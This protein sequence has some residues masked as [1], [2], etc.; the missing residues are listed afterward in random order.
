MASVDSSLKKKDR[1]DGFLS[2]MSLA[3]LCI[4]MFYS[5]QI[6]IL[7]GRSYVVYLVIFLFC[8]IRMCF[9]RHTMSHRNFIACFL[10]LLM[11]SVLDLFHITDFPSL[12]VYVVRHVCLVWLVILLSDVEKERLVDVFTKIY[13]AIVGVSLLSF[14]LYSLGVDLPYTTVKYELSTGYSDFKCYPFLLIP[15]ELGTVVRF[16]SVFLEPGHLGMISSLLLYVNRY[17]LKQLRVLILLLSVLVS[18]SLAAYVL[19]IIGAILHYIMNSKRALKRVVLSFVYLLLIFIVGISYYIYD[20]DSVFSQLIVERLDYSE[21]KGIRGNN[22]TSASFDSFYDGFFKTSDCLLGIDADVYSA[23]FGG[24]S[25]GGNSSYKTFIV[26][27]GLI[28][29]FVLTLFYLIYTY[30]HKSRLLMGFLLLYSA[31][32]WQ[33]PYA[34]WEVEL[35]LFIGVAICWDNNINR[36]IYE[37]KGFIRISK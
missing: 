14:T 36:K 15:N 19:L 29:L 30:L 1:I 9:L 31:S 33:R 37:D 32:F 27:Y 16:Q 22:R 4:I 17:R 25:G 3:F 11:Y 6:Y 34:L 35:F 5:M 18:L 26:Q 12:V 20:P 21:E 7:W 2:E 13:V 10:C 28:G 23:K 8:A 24:V